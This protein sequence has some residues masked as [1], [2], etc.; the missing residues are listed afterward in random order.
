M[1]TE[2]SFPAP[3][4][5]SGDAP[6][7][8]RPAALIGPTVT[9][10]QAWLALMALVVGFFMLLVDSTIVSVSIPAIMEAFHTDV[11][12]VIW[13]TS[14][15][16]LGYAVPLLIM[17]R[18]GDRYGPR[19][20]YLIG[21][22]IFTASS[23]WCGFAHSIEALIIA[24]GVQ[25]LGAAMMAPQSMAV[26]TRLFPPARRGAAMGLWG[27][28]AGIATLIGPILGGVLTDSWGWPWIFWVNVPI[29]II[30]LVAVY[31]LVPRLPRT[32]HS[33]DTLGVF[34]NGLAT[35]AVVFALQEGQ[36]Y[37]WDW[38]VWALL[39]AGG[40]LFAA[41]ILWQVYNKRE[42]L[43]PL[44]LFRDR[45]FTLANV[46]V[47]LMGVMVTSQVFPT[48]LFLQAARGLTPTQ[49]ALLTIPSALLS[50]V[51]APF[52]GGLTDKFGPKPFLIVGAVSMSAGLATYGLL[53]RPEPSVLWFLTPSALTGLGGSMIWGPLSVSATR[54]LPVRW[55]GAGSGVYNATRQLGAVLG[56]A[57]IAALIENQLVTRL[58]QTASKPG[59]Q[60]SGQR[61]PDVLQGPYSAAM[62][63]AMLLPVT[64][65]G[66]A[67]LAVL[68]I[69]NARRDHLADGDT[70]HIA[71][72]AG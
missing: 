36:S 7:A 42:P 50:L 11:S 17:G 26:I 63:T 72:D 32:A 66:L 3:P 33:F 61:L 43:L 47:F 49:A 12:A 16:L 62:S 69:Q 39:A 58:P 10:R 68:A 53:M 4:C 35:F 41:F 65:L 64:C 60:A 15:Y 30:G 1:P 55:A 28:T 57:A 2:S 51:L 25:G 67:L 44:G 34:L 22:F 52:I 48:M 37:D 56:S 46:T 31:V 14:A 23:L 71:T 6:A 13:V 38:R 18:L 19:T 59:M 70:P 21:L 20:I 8:R 9:D 29:G 27:A 45:N 5:D 54:G 40:G 24:R